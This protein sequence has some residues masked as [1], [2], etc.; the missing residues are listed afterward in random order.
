MYKNTEIFNLKLDYIFLKSIILPHKWHKNRSVFCKIYRRYR[1][2]QSAAKI[3]SLCKVNEI[4]LIFVITRIY[5][6]LNYSWLG[7]LLCQTSSVKLKERKLKVSE[8][9]NANIW[10]LPREMWFLQLIVSYLV[11]SITLNSWEPHDGKVWPCLPYYSNQGTCVTREVLSVI[12]FLNF[13]K[14]CIVLILVL[15]LVHQELRNFVFSPFLCFLG[16]PWV[17]HNCFSG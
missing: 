8:S 1:K 16:L 7:A 5:S 11:L 14:F 9:S 4:M 17:S 12:L 3:V 2:S 6:Q 13:S 10:W 15:I